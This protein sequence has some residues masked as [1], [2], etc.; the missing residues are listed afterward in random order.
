MKN[1]KNPFLLNL[2]ALL[3]QPIG[4]HQEF[5]F[6]IEQVQFTDDFA[7]AAFEGT[8]TVSRTTQGLV[9]QGNFEGELTLQCA[10]CLKDYAHLL[11][12]EITEL[13]AFDPDEATDDD[14]LL[15]NNAKVDIKPILADE[16]QL[17]VPINPICKEDCQ[18]LCQICGTDLNLGDCEHKDIPPEDERENPNSPFSGLKDL[19]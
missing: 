4:S 16:A 8:L 10:R 17:N 1:E 5:P 9:A 2:G 14:L 18:G 6:E 7:L 13:Y 15:P 11:E 12:W 3:S 19:L